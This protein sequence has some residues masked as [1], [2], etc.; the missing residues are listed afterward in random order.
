MVYYTKRGENVAKD[1]RMDYRFCRASFFGAYL[2]VF[3]ILYVGIATP[4]NEYDAEFDA[5]G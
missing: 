2:V 1:F 5:R 3:F 4:G